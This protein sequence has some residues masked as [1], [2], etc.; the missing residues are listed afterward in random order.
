M[1]YVASREIDP[2]LHI[3]THI[4]IKWSIAFHKGWRIL[5]FPCLADCILARPLFPTK[6][7]PWFYGSCA[8]WVYPRR[9]FHPTFGFRIK[10]RIPTRCGAFKRDLNSQYCLVAGL[11]LLQGNKHSVKKTLPWSV[12]PQ[13]PL[14]SLQLI[15]EHTHS[16]LCHS[17]SEMPIRARIWVF[18]LCM[19]NQSLLWSKFHLCSAPSEPSQM[20]LT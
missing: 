5:L 10:L 2:L 20:A 18:L 15:C 9:N 12:G 4:L 14:F 13:I 7:N 17:F 11:L 8:S 19:R 16:S 1:H 6:M 3:C